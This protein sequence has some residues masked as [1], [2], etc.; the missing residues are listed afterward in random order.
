M[1]SKRLALS[2]L[3]L[4]SW[5]VCLTIGCVPLGGEDLEVSSPTDTGQIVS[6]DQLS[7]VNRDNQDDYEIIGS[8]VE[9]GAEVEY[10]VQ[11]LQAARDGGH[12]L[13]Q[14]GRAL[15]QK[16]R[17]SVSG[18]DLSGIS[19]GA[20]VEIKASMKRVSLEGSRRDQL[21]TEQ[22]VATTAILKD[23]TLPIIFVETT[24]LYINQTNQD[25][26]VLS[27]T[28]SEPGEI[29]FIV[30]S[31]N[32][33]TPCTTDG[34]WSVS[35]DLSQEFEGAIPIAVEL[36]DRVG[37]RSRPAQIDKIKDT[38]LPTV[39]LDAPP[40]INIANEQNYTL[41][42]NCSEEGQAIEVNLSGGNHIVSSSQAPP[43]CQSDG[44]WQITLDVRTLEESR[45]EVAVAH[46]DEAGNGAQPIRKFT[47]KDITPPGLRNEEIAVPDNGNYAGGSLSFAIGFTEPVVVDAAS[48][49]PCITLRVGSGTAYA[50]YSSG[51][52]SELL[53]FRYI[54]QAGDAGTGI[55]SPDANYSIHLNGGV[56]ADTVGNPLTSLALQVPSLSGLTID[57]RWPTI[58]AIVPNESHRGPDAYYRAGES[59]GLTVTFSEAV[60]ITGNPQLILDMGGIAKRASYAG[61]NGATATHHNF[62]LTIASGD[63]D[64]DGIAVTGVET[65]SSIVNGDSYQVAG[66]LAPAWRIE[67]VIA[68]T[69]APVVSGLS[70]EENPLAFKNWRWGCSDGTEATCSYRYAIN[71]H[72]SHQF[73]AHTPYED[74]EGVTS[75]PGLNGSYY[76]HVQARD[77]AGN[78]SPGDQRLGPAR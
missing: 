30:A 72:P 28:C 49:T 1:V 73:F 25:P 59:V 39:S 7:S 50:S 10:T 15:C 74:R 32:G 40:A 36:V 29:F 24:P 60:T 21:T 55:T 17:W 41:T 16:G 61:A 71:R 68:D 35:L 54:I 66:A 23:I 58:V 48:G 19:D 76:L 62:T 45:V 3:V 27:G 42:G 5:N 78:E 18:L 2:F 77:G 31:H 67:E 34:T 43:L 52:G 13:K 51:S 46:R 56:I 33:S 20:K 26:F 65:A 8:C 11:S 12:V 53:T 70:D 22:G 63:N 14:R 57:G 47:P 4:G 75:P 69:T 37:N 64:E 38:I 44:R 9:E 6:V